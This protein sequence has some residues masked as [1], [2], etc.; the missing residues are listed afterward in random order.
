MFLYYLQVVTNP[1]SNWNLET[2]V[3]YSSKTHNMKENPHGR[4]GKRQY[5]IACES[6]YSIRNRTQSVIIEARTTNEQTPYHLPT[7]P[8]PY[9]LITHTSWSCYRALWKPQS[10]VFG[11]GI[12]FKESELPLTTGIQN[13]NFTNKE[14]W[15]HAVPGIRNPQRGIDNFKLYGINWPLQ[16][17]HNIP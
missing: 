10:W 7:T 4:A 13:P 14:S 17:Y 8:A 3:S 12:Q 11:T 16:K 9:P 1:W 2:L 15:I 5:R 6:Q